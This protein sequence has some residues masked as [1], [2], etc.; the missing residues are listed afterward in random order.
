MYMLIS[1]IK[2]LSTDAAARFRLLKSLTQGNGNRNGSD[3]SG[4]LG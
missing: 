4:G 2:F 3:W 1:L